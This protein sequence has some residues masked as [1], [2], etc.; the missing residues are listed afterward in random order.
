MKSHNIT[1][2]PIT[3]LLEEL[4]GNILMGILQQ[5][6]TVQ[7]DGLT[8]YVPVSQNDFF[9]ACYYTMFIDLCHLKF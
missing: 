7:W 2:R 5:E 3:N 9:F 4:K 8:M 6:R 1:H